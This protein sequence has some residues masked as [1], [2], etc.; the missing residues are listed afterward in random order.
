M[1]KLNTEIAS[2]INR[3][4]VLTHIHEN[5]NISRAELARMT[6]MDRSTITHILNYLIQE[7]VV[8]EREKGQASAQGGR[9]PIQLSVCYEARTLIAAEVSLDAIK[10]AATDLNGTL[11]HEISHPIDRG[12]DLV[13]YLIKAIDKLRRE[14]PEAFDKRTAIGISLPGIVNVNEGV[15]IVSEY[16]GWHNINVAEALRE[17]YDT[18]VFVEN[19]ANAAATGELNHL[20]QS[21]LTSMIFLFIRESPPSHETLLGAGGALI[22]NNKLWHGAH[23]HAGELAH[24]IN[25]SFHKSNI[26][27]QKQFKEHTALFD[28]SLSS[29]LR[30]AEQGDQRAYNIIDIV[31]D[32]IA[33]TICHLEAFLD[34]RVIMV[35]V[36][37]SNDRFSDLIQDGFW[38]AYARG[39]R[40]AVQFIKP[41]LGRDAMIRGTINLLQEKIFVRDSS[42]ISLLFGESLSKAI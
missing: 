12:A 41:S 1:R 27:E 30:A 8:A 36:D 2:R 5:P 14:A 38:R 11:I 40:R 33:D 23:H 31:V 35:Y 22:I 17:K 4:L 7:K 6:G 42:S 13:Q 18:P 25:R 34:P 10:C 15:L 39:D 26:A 24:R 21:D 20:K 32:H 19:D 3:S 16:H 9:R 37:D 29:V 28:N